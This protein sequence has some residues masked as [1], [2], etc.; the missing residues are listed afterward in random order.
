MDL[1]RVVITE[2]S[3]SR[4]VEIVFA[5]VSNL[6]EASQFLH[7]RCLVGHGGNPVTPELQLEALRT[8]RTLVGD[9][10]SRLESLRDQGT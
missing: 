9:E 3:T 5:N 1:R 7:L 8:A 6:E 4:H 2:T 10:I